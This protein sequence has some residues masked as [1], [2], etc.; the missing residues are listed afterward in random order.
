VLWGRMRALFNAER[1]PQKMKDKL[2]GEVAMTATDIENLLVSKNPSKPSYERFF[3][4]EL[5]KAKHR[6]QVGQ[7]AVI[8]VTKK[9]QPKLQNHGIHAIYLGRARDHAAD[10]HRSL[11]LGTGLIMISRDV[12]WFNKVY[13]NQGDQ[14]RHDRMD[15]G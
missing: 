5:P 10:T 11:N 14:T 2:W 13:G 4:R 12:I 9:V 7:V 15:P 8:K 6:R 1:I 3:H